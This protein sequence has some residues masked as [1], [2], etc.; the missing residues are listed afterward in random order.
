MEISNPCYLA[1]LWPSNS[2][3]KK[4]YE[5]FYYLK[6]NLSNLLHEIKVNNDE[7]NEKVYTTDY[8]SNY[9]LNN[10]INYNNIKKCQKFS[11]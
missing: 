11:T 8:N 10:F 5:I 3:K 7:E 1:Y 4:C 6:N 9:L 2:N